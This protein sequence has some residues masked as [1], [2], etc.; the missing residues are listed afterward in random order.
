MR[1]LPPSPSIRIFNRYHGAIACGAFPSLSGMLVGERSV[2]FRA[3][4]GQ[5]ENVTRRPLAQRNSFER[6]NRIRVARLLQLTVWR[7]RFRSLACRNGAIKTQLASRGTD[8]ETLR[9]QRP[10]RLLE[11]VAR[12]ARGSG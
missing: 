6:V 1:S 9:K 12:R 2:S 11:L 5:V 4:L 7:P 3:S 8:D 10:L